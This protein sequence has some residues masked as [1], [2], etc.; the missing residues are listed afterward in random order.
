MDF[1]MG[2]RDQTSW[3][4]ERGAHPEIGSGQAMSD[5][6]TALRAISNDSQ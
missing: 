1:K 5:G 2:N 3:I 6:S 4:P